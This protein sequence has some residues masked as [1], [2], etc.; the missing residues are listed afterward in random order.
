M[1]TRTEASKRSG[2]TGNGWI[3][4][5]EG[6]GR[7]LNSELQVKRRL[8]ITQTADGSVEQRQPA[9]RPVKKRAG[10]PSK[11]DDVVVR[12]PTDDEA[13]LLE[14]I[15]Y[16]REHQL[17]VDEKFIVGGMACGIGGAIV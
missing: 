2:E 14:R 3:I 4:K 5:V 1:W 11:A 7:P 17:A 13:R 9:A 16:V 15:D 10:R 8:G 12:K 6:D